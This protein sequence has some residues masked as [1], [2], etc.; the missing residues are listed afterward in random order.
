MRSG[1]LYR[2]VVCDVEVDGAW[3]VRYA[4]VMA[5]DREMFL[6]GSRFYC[7]GL[8]FVRTR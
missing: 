6:G 7:R 4:A 3:L 1:A 8:V 5:M 2:E